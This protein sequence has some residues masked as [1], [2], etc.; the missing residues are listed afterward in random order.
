[1]IHILHNRHRF[2]GHSMYRP[3]IYFEV[4]SPIL[5]YNTIFFGLEM[6]NY[7]KNWSLD[8]LIYV[9]MCK[10]MNVFSLLSYVTN[11]NL[12]YN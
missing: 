1:M 7:K 9:T 8:L 6:M 12:K 2:H 10:C 11:A 5:Y 4:V 3:Y